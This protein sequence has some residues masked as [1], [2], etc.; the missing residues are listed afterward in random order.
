MDLKNSNTG[1]W[2]TGDYNTG[3]W[4]TGDWNT[5]Y[6]NTV[7]PDEC[8]IFNKIGS[9]DDWMQAEKP[10][11]MEVALTQW[12]TDNDMHSGGYLKRYSSIKEAYIES[13]ENATEEDKQLTLKLPNFDDD[14]FKEIFGFSAIKNLNK[15]IK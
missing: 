10:K 14:V 12:I 8:L 11:W 2:N 7:T 13:W 4:N 9:R 6:C 3:N 15:P 1:D 5:G